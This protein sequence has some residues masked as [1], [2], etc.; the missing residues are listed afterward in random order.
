MN[1]ELAEILMEGDEN[2][3]GREEETVIESLERREESS[4]SNEP[5]GESAV[6]TNIHILDHITTID[7]NN[8]NE[9]ERDG[10]ASLVSFT[11]SLYSDPA[12]AQNAAIILSRIN[13][14]TTATTINTVNA[15]INN[16]AVLNNNNNNQGR[17]DI[18]SRRGVNR[19][20]LINNGNNILVN[21]VQ[22]AETRELPPDNN[23]VLSEQHSQQ[24]QHQQQPP[25]PLSLEIMTKED[26][27][28]EKL[29]LSGKPQ[30]WIA[31]NNPARFVKHWKLNTHLD[32]TKSI[33]I[34]NGISYPDDILQ[35]AKEIDLYADVCILPETIIPNVYDKATS[36]IRSVKIT[37]NNGDRT[38]VIARLGNVGAIVL[39]ESNEKI[40]N[41]LQEKVTY[42]LNTYNKENQSAIE[43]AVV[44]YDFI[45]ESNLPKATTPSNDDKHKLPTYPYARNEES[46]LLS[47]TM[48][49]IQVL[50]RKTKSKNDNCNYDDE[51][52]EMNVNDEDERKKKLN[53]DTSNEADDDNY[54]STFSRFVDN[55]K[56]L[57]A[58]A[59][60]ICA[61]SVPVNGMCAGPSD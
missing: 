54:S 60:P 48:D 1:E 37:V 20:N 59:Q 30:S 47:K 6:D 22:S 43:L 13:T 17:S 28:F 19:V 41:L 12:A 56:F 38:V 26:I 33:L 24:Q 55:F 27:A 32:T 52:P 45:S 10:C 36:K 35:V 40:R 5:R 11:S 58:C 14:T 50:S 57:A 49:F 8:D 53:N 25:I 23:T 39:E 34:L 29:L 2:N 46:V 15:G 31:M 16:T 61:C 3:E 4:L 7:T 21:R 51:G 18:T 9:E 44:K 42:F